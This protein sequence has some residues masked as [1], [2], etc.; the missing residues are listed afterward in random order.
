MIGIAV[1]LVP[2]TEAKPPV[3]IPTTDAF[4]EIQ[5]TCEVT[6]FVVLSL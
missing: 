4:P 2:C 6:F 1:V 3:E 5:V